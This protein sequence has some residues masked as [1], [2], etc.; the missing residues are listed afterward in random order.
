MRVLWWL[1]KAGGGKGLIYY[2]AFYWPF[3]L[4]TYNNAPPYRIRYLSVFLAVFRLRPQK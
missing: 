1:S 4:Y 3:F 2:S